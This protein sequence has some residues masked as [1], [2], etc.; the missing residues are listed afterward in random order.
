M[1]SLFKEIYQAIKS[2]KD[3][4]SF[5]FPKQPTPALKKRFRTYSKNELIG[6]IW[7]Q[8]KTILIQQRQLDASK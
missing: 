3:L 6:M 7:E 4:P 2:K 5:T 1:F 8:Q